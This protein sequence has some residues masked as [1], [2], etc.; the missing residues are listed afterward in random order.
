[1]IGTPKK[2]TERRDPQG[3][4]FTIC[5]WKRYE[6]WSRL[7][8]STGR[9]CSFSHHPFPPPRLTLPPRASHG[10]GLVPSQAASS[11]YRSVPVVSPR[12]GA[13][14]PM[15]VVRD[16]FTLLASTII[17]LW[18]SECSPAMARSISQR[19]LGH[20]GGR[21]RTLGRRR[22]GDARAPLFALL[23]VLSLHAS[24][25]TATREGE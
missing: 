24:A 2:P 20:V 10:D 3:G 25:A 5:T 13:S 6:R 14:A 18:P 22:L 16:C 12:L 19:T 17:A 15:S 11:R 9:K 4:R 23:F 8:P 7:L 1:M 21:G